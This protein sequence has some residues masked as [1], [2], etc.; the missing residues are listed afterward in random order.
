MRDRPLPDWPRVLR[1]SFAAAYCGVS[2]SSFRIHIARNVRAISPTP[3]TRAW[4]REDLDDYLD[5][6]RGT[7]AASKE[8]NPWHS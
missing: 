1:E 6:L 4:L 8:R 5:G 7:V 2:E 3:G